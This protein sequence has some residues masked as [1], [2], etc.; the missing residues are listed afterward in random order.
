MHSRN[1]TSEEKHLNICSIP[2]TVSGRRLERDSVRAPHAG[3]TAVL[4]CAL[5]CCAV[6]A[7][8]PPHKLSPP[9]GGTPSFAEPPRSVQVVQQ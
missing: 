3:S 8:V 9:V 7:L 4:G 6:W 5:I 2:L 1:I